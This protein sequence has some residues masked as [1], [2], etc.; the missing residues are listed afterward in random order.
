MR[1]VRAPHVTTP[2]QLLDRLVAILGQRRDHHPPAAEKLGAAAAGAPSPPRRWACA[3]TNWPIRPSAPCA[4]A[5]PLALGA[6]GIGDDASGPS[7]N[8]FLTRCDRPDQHENRPLGPLPDRSRSSIAPRSSASFMFPRC[9]RCRR[10]AAGLRL[11]Q[12]EREEPP[13]GRPDHRYSRRALSRKL[14]A[15]AARNFCSPRVPTVTRR[16][17]GQAVAGDRPH[18]HAPAKQRL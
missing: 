11:L 5:A 1:L 12:R 2:V 7:K 13:M 6:A 4:A 18:D 16:V 9:A 10:R 17:L 15:S 3:G 14:A 8:D